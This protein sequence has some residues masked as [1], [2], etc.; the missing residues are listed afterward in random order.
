MADNILAFGDSWATVGYPQLKNVLEPLGFNVSIR[1]IAGTPAGYWAY[2]QPEALIKAIDLY[3]AKYVYF[4]LGGDDFLESMPLG[5]SPEKV[6][7]EMITATRKLLDELFAKRPTVQVFHFGYDLLDWSASSFCKD[8]GDAELK[9]PTPIFCPAGWANTTCMT[10]N[11]AEWLQSR[12]VDELAAHYRSTNDS[13]Y[14]G[15]NLLGTLQVAGG[16]P[17][18]RVGSPVWSA[19]SPTRFV[20]KEHDNLGCVHLT[21]AGFTSLY[22][23]LAKHIVKVRDRAGNTTVTMASQAASVGASAS[24]PSRLATLSVANAPSAS[25]SSL[26][27]EG[28]RYTRRPCFSNPRR[29]CWVAS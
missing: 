20:R 14:H 15:L 13:Q 11:Q 25:W 24:S 3:Y 9:G 28:T 22:S 7:G 6:H 4:S 10:R 29:M 26:A 1:A 23:E 17:G 8:F 16:V 18:A 5:A 2:V 19:Y 12:Y 27:V 21:P